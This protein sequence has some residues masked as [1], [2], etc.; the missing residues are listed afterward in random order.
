MK[1]INDYIN[2]Y[3]INEGSL[4][5]AKEIFGKLKN[6][7][8]KKSKSLSKEDEELLNDFLW[9]VDTSELDDD[10]KKELANIFKGN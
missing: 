8:N 9:A 5:K 6:I 4:D 1:N 7:I 10:T 3:E 2:E